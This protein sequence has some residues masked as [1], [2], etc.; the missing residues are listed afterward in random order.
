MRVPTV[1]LK[2]KRKKNLV[3]TVNESDWA[4]DL[5]KYQ[6]SNWER[7]GERHNEAAAPL[8]V[9]PVERR[10]EHFFKDAPQRFELERATSEPPER[11]G[12]GRPRKNP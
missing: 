6:W 10:N 12:R 7:V 5:G 8:E 2:H 1:R 11:R 9:K 4:Q 3:I